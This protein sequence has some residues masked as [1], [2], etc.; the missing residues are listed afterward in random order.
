[1]GNITISAVSWDGFNISWELKRGDLEGFLI[2]VADPAGLSKGQNHTLS[3]LEHN[4]AITDLSPSTFYRVTL[5]GQYKGGLI[6]PVFGEAL[7]GTAVRRAPAHRLSFENSNIFS[8][9]RMKE[10]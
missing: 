9:S 2:E 8:G 6:E 3:G 7:T 4:L 1:M 10:Y 5:Y